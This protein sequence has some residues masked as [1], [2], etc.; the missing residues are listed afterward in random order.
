MRTLPLAAHEAHQSAATSTSSAVVLRVLQLNTL[1]HWSVDGETIEAFRSRTLLH[2]AHVRLLSPDVCVLEEIDGPKSL[3]DASG[4]QS[5]PQRLITPP[6]DGHGG[7]E[8]VTAYNGA[9][10]SK[11]NDFEDQTWILFNTAKFSLHRQDV[12]RFDDGAA[13]QAALLVLLTVHH[14]GE[15]LLVIAQHAKAGRTEDS[16]AI[17]IRHTRQLVAHLAHD[18]EYSTMLRCGRCLW[19]GDF[20]AGPHSYG[21]RYPAAWYPEVVPSLFQSMG[22]ASAYAEFG[23]GEPELTTY[24]W[25]KGMLLSQCIDYIFYTPRGLRLTAI[26]PMPSED[27][28]ATA[29]CGAGLPAA[30]LWGSDHLSL[31][32]DFTMAAPEGPCADS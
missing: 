26:L 8:A 27:D 5:L 20:N 11:S 15:H 23:A 29:T 12:F 16:E 19:V 6:S 3:P 17:R 28:V 21:G 24:K 31:V 7:D 2:E 9:F 18:S 14:T 10:V 32:C 25:R 30:G 22:L 13:S 4:V 1:S